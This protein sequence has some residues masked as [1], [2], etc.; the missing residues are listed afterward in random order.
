MSGVLSFGP[1]VSAGTQCFQGLAMLQHVSGFH[2]SL[3]LNSI[4][5]C[6]YTA[7]VYSLIHQMHTWVASI[8]GSCEERR[9]QH[10]YKTTSVLLL[11]VLWGIGPQVEFLGSVTIL[12][13]T[14]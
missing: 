2:S 8:F 12:C 7:F 5:L 9:Y 6:V 3:R 11:C 1:L 13:L 4:L 10:S 14:F